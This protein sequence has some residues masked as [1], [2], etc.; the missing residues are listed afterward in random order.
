MNYG[1]ALCDASVLYRTSVLDCHQNFYEETLNY[2]GP[3]DDGLEHGGGPMIRIVRLSLCV[4]C[5]LF[6]VSG[7]AD[8]LA[9][10][11]YAAVDEFTV[12]G[13]ASLHHGKAPLSAATIPDMEIQFSAMDARSVSISSVRFFVTDTD[14][15]NDSDADDLEFL[16]SVIVYI[17]PVDPASELPVV[18]LAR[19]E[20]PHDAGAQELWLDALVDVDLTDY[21]RE[22]F[23]LKASTTGVVP[24]DDVSVSGEATFRVNPI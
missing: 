4:L 1:H 13:D 18:E 19:W 11:L 23:V 17:A 8:V 10:D 16:D 21:I 22:G 9:F 24:Y 6:M 2:S 12:P 5:T 3:P 7:C 14:L 20:G 15:F